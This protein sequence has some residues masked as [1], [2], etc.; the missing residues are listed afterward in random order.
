[1]K[2]AALFSEDIYLS[3]Q[4][5]RKLEWNC[6]SRILWVKAYNVVSHTYFTLSLELH[7]AIARLEADTKQTYR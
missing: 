7:H 1:M 4:I 3:K 5:M 6:L 2:P